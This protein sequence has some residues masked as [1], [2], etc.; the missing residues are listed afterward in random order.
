[1]SQTKAQLIDGKSAEIEFTGGSASAPAISFTGDPNTGIYSPGADQVA[2]ATNGTG[3]LFV[4]S[5]GRVTVTSSASP[6]L[7]VNSAIQLTGTG[8]SEITTSDASGL[9]LTCNSNVFFLQGNSD[10][11]FRGAAATSYAER[12]RITSAGLVG[13]GTSSPDNLLHVKASGSYGGIIADNSSTTGGGTFRAYQNGSLRGTF[14]ASGAIEGNTTSDVGL[15]AETG[16]LRFYTN[17]SAVAA[18]AILDSSGRLGIGT[19]SPSAELHVNPG[20]GN[21]GNVRIDNG[22]GS[23]ADGYLN[24]E[25]NSGGALYETLKTG[26][27]AHV[28]YNTGAERMRIDTAGRLLVGTSTARSNFNNTTDTTRLQIEGTDAA[29]SSLSLV[30]NNGGGVPVASIHLAKSDG[31]SIGSTGAVAN[32]WDLGDIRFSGSDGTE[33]V[34]AASIACEVDGT[35]GANDMPGR[36]VFSTT[37]DGASNPGEAMRIS[38]GRNVLLSGCP[39]D[40]L[41]V[42]NT[43]GAGTTNTFIVGRYSNSAGTTDGTISLLVYTNGN[44]QN[45][46]N[47]YGAISDIKLKENIVDANSQWDD[48]KAL[49]VRNYNF[50]EPASRPTP[51][52]VLSPKKLNS[53]PLVSSANPLTATK[54]ATTLAPS[55]RASTTRCS[56]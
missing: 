27:L 3:R 1:M 22:T 9:Y 30:C 46:N 18:K 16:G 40:T 34:Q 11:I 29:T 45:T 5:L 23:S 43:S 49:Q 12:L 26:G 51:K 31:A 25:V 53:S 41:N 32:N 21:A 52:S 37:A 24:V 13:I 47:S 48:L 14:G 56:T 55:P 4:D 28:W 42:T 20:S 19:T 54:K 7:S 10:F 6:A 2:V 15:F 8:T 44:V 17:G 38:S 35:P 36:L 39:G 50:K 33:F